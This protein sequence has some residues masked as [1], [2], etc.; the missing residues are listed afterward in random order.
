MSSLSTHFAQAQ[1]RISG[2]AVT[3]ELGEAGRR[4]RDLACQ[5]NP[6][7][8]SADQAVVIDLETPALANAD[9]TPG[10]KSFSPRSKRQALVRLGALG[11]VGAIAFVVLTWLWFLAPNVTADPQAA[12]AIIVLAGG[13]DRT[14]KGAELAAAGLAPVIVYADP[15]RNTGSVTANPYCNG[16]EQLAIDVICVDPQPAKTQGEARAAM[17]L[18]A[19]RGWE[20][21]IVVAST[22]Q[23]TRARRLFNRCGDI[24]LQMVDVEH[25]SSPLSRAAYEWGAT[26]K[27][28]TI[29]RG[30]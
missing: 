11:F 7:V 13:G 20:N 25:D 30:C 10:D 28:H 18:A 5:V 27:A 12:D 3:C 17:L 22:D 16:R 6:A 9:G 29:K 26:L 21:L 4:S 19:E 23:V 1:Q 2:S 24:E 8:D 15:G 14:G